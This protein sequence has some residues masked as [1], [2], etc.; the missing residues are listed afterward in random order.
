MTVLENL[1]QL[2]RHITT[3]DQLK[4]VKKMVALLEMDLNDKR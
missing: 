1:K 4:E 2:L 3:K